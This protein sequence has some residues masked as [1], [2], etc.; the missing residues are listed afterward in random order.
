MWTIHQNQADMSEADFLFVYL[1]TP[2]RLQQLLA[3][4]FRWNSSAIGRS[5]PLSVG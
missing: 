4:I 3:M 5:K 1:G 2:P